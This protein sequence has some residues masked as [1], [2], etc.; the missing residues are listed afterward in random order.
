MAATM[1]ESSDVEL[2]SR[3]AAQDGACALATPNARVAVTVQ[4]RDD[5]M[6]RH[7]SV[8]GEGTPCTGRIPARFPCRTIL[9]GFARV[10]GSIEQFQRPKQQQ[11]Q[12]QEEKTIAIVFLV[13]WF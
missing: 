7:M 5:R 11:Q 12:Q 13:F 6:T 2:E 4:A 10:R 1:A 8:M 3:R 9:P